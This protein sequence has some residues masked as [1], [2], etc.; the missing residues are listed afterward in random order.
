MKYYINSILYNVDCGLRCDKNTYS[1]FIS[2]ILMQTKNNSFQNILNCYVIYGMVEFIS[3]YCYICDKT[4]AEE[5]WQ[6]AVGKY[7]IYYLGIV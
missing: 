1:Y 5:K 4:L 7:V 3:V 6:M 2:K